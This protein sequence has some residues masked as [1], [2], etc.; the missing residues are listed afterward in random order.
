MRPIGFLAISLIGLFLAA[1]CQP[2][3]G[4]KP[5][6]KPAA[7][8]TPG[9]EATP[10]RV[11]AAKVAPLTKSLPVTGS[12]AAT[13]SVELSAKIAA[14]L[15]YIAG[16][17]GETVRA[18]QVALRQDT[19]DLQTQVTA[20]EAA[21]QQAEAQVASAMANVR[22]AEARLA[23]AR[24]Q[25]RV[26]TTSSD[27]GVRDAEQQLASARQGLEL[28]KKPQRTQEV[29]VAENAVASA[30]ASY[31]K[32]AT[33]KKRY[34]EL[35]KE[36]A[37]AQMAYEQYETQEKVARAQLDTAKQQLT[38]AR[39][40]G[41]A[42][43]I[44]QAQTTVARAEWAVRLARANTKQNDVRKDDIAGSEASL[45][46]ARASL[47]QSQAG[48]AQ[49]RANVRAARQ[50]VD[51]GVV[52][53]PIDGVISKRAAEPGQMASPGATALT[54]VALDSVFFEAQVPET[55]LAAVR[56]GLPVDVSLD[57]YRGRTFAG[58]I[59]KLYPAGSTSSRSFVVRVA[60]PNESGALR[61]GMFA[62][63]RIVQERRSGV[64]VPKDAIVRTD[65]GP[66]VFVVEGN[67]A[68]RRAI[69]PGLSTA[70]VL[71][72]KKGVGVGDRIV[73]TGQTGLRDGM[74]IQIIEPKTQT[75][76]TAPRP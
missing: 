2:P 53:A 67:R 65:S 5:G 24:T 54:L 42:E 62:R 8:P 45:S 38:L 46:Q 69:E 72:V 33:D 12:L 19:S 18:G 31:E 58:R 48:V 44:Q 51:D 37:V 34:A 56:L 11:S 9:V 13:Q 74:P 60:I 17:E 6:G 64:V 39:E 28:A 32:A 71:E 29:R 66:V 16:R 4:G 76:E 35:L 40:G 49:A 25:A 57:A 55:D 7:S 10:V 20:N 21:L 73:V 1:G 3:D 61:P 75:A 30:Q 59:A 63:G 27:A 70:E 22:S 52:T 50:R 41:R 14:R 26:Q 36:G 43:A 15:T 68:M 23:T 47:A